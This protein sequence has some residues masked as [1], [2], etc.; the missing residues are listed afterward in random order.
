MKKFLYFSKNIF[1]GCEQALYDVEDFESIEL[2]QLN[3]EIEIE[4]AVCSQEEINADLSDTPSK[5]KLKR[6]IRA[7]SI[8]RLEEAAR[9]ADE[10]KIVVKWWDRLDDNRERKERYHEV[11][12]GDNVPLDYNAVEDGIHYPRNLN[13]FIWRQI[14]KGEFLDAIYNCPYE[15]HELVT[16]SYLS[17]ILDDLKIEHK[18]LLYYI[19]IRQYSSSKIAKLK[20]QSDRNIRNVKNTILKKARRK[21]YEYLTFNNKH[22]MTIEEELFMMNYAIIVDR[23]K[24]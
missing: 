11:S 9:T 4:N 17:N 24:K 16:E 13:H 18:E 3:R 23:N 19:A 15:I 5:K 6:E 22:S 8:L 10:F 14:Q 21:I 7:E 2:E 12:R 1:I 20:G